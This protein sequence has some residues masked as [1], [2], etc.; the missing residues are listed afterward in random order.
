[1]IL[2]EFIMVNITYSTFQF[3]YYKNRIRKL[4]NCSIGPQ[5][6]VIHVCVYVDLGSFTL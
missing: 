5:V 3:L 2:L 1:M 4:N 6:K